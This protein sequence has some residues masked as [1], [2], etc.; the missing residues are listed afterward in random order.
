MSIIGILGFHQILLSSEISRW[1]QNLLSSVPDTGKKAGGSTTTSNIPIGMTCAG[2]KTPFFGDHLWDRRPGT[3]SPLQSFSFYVN[4]NAWDIYRRRLPAILFLSFIFIDNPG[5]CI[6]LVANFIR[7]LCVI[8]IPF[9]SAETGS[10]L[11]SGKLQGIFGGK[12]S[13]AF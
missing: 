2:K 10:P 4:S 6:T 11:F 3:S 7:A 9:G 12:D 13:Y 8:E 5:F 1:W